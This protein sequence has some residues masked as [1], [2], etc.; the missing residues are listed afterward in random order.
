MQKRKLGKNGPEVPA[1]G[2]GCMG[3]S[4][5]Y[6]EPQRRRVDRHHSPGARARR[7]SARH[8]GCLWR[9]RQRGAGRQGDRRA[10][11]TRSLIGTKFGNLALAGRGAAAVAR[12][13]PADIRIT[14]RQACDAEPEAP[15]RGHD[16]HLRPAPR[17]PD[18]C[19]SRTRSA[20]CSGWSSRARCAISRCR[21]PARRRSAAR[22]RC[23]PSPRSKP[24]IRCGAATSSATSCP[25][26]ASSA[27]ASWPTRRSAAAFSPA[28]IKT[29]DALLPKDRRRE[30][31]RFDAANIETNRRAARAARRRSRRR[32]R[33]TPAQIALA[34]LL[35]QGDDIVPIPGTKRRKYLEENC[36]A[37]DLE[38]SAGRDRRS[39]TRRSR[40]SHRRN[41]LSGEAATRARYLVRAWPCP[42]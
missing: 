9:R 3:M 29:L 24:S 11:A 12:R 41:A 32:T 16:R 30:H 23:I 28:T 40:P 19:R 27:S 22:T 13:S 33:A 4:I 2:L 42:R 35:A 5:S 18:A 20:R 25:R 7:E 36:A 17:R 8:L 31:P 26:A 34:W 6:G 38:L 39:S 15:G 21:K 10:S 1:V 37:A 14:C